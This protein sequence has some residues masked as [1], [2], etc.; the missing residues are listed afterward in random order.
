MNLIKNRTELGVINLFN[1]MFS[2]KAL[3][4]EP[5]LSLCKITAIYDYDSHSFGDIKPNSAIFVT[6]DKR[7]LGNSQMTVELAI[8]ERAFCR[9]YINEEER[10][11]AISDWIGYIAYHL[12]TSDI[13]RSGEAKQY[14]GDTF[15]CE[16]GLAKELLRLIYRRTKTDP[17]NAEFLNVMRN[18]IFIIRSLY[19]EQL[20]FD[21]EKSNHTLTHIDDSEDNEYKELVEGENPLL[22][23]D[24]FGVIYSLSKNELVDITKSLPSKYYVDNDTHVILENA[25]QPRINHIE[26]RT[27]LR[28]LYLPDELTDIRDG[29]FNYNEALTYINIPLYV[30]YIGAN[31]F[32]G[33]KRLH[34][35]NIQSP[36][37]IKVGTL[38]FNKERTR[39]IAC[40]PSQCINNTGKFWPLLEFARAHGK[41]QVGTFTNKDTEEHFHSCI[42]TNVEGVRIFCA[43][44]S[45]L[46]ELSP[47]EIANRKNELYVLQLPSG[48]YSLC[49]EKQ[50]FIA[51][52]EHVVLEEGL[53]YIDSNAFFGDKNLQEI[54][55]PSSLI[56]IG[57]NA[58][59]GCTSLKRINIPFGEREK[60]E[61][62]I[63]EAKEKLFEMQDELRLLQNYKLPDGSIYN[64]EAITH[65]GFI[66]LNGQGTIKYVNGDSYKGSFRNGIPNGWG[67]YTFRNGDTH[68]GYFDNLPNGIGYLNEVYS[69]SVGNFKDGRMNGWGI[70]YHNHIFKFGLWK[71]GRLI[72][73]ETNK[74]L[75]IRYEISSL[76]LEGYHASLIQ[77]DKDGSYIRF[78]IPERLM[79]KELGELP[80]APKWPALGFEFYNDGSVK[81]GIIKGHSE[82][83]YIL[84]KTDGSMVFGKWSKNK[85]LKIK[86]LSD[87]QGNTDNYTI[88]GFDVF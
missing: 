64:G 19:G 52:Q 65:W 83:N 32:A 18:R 61:E 11:V 29:A 12:K 70:R 20:N 56:E 63:P 16:L 46:G 54:T 74:T 36:N 81:V 6:I 9:T 77:I 4:L 33:C 71:E 15:V 14:V 35:V 88:D 25:L 84:C 82:G 13:E 5:I 38:L 86:T 72:Q 55:L 73:D 44:S 58:F 10:L 87:F 57:P 80:K 78:G 85:I 28:Q 31:P 69:M 47:V 1:S 37:F 76:R 75:W 34:Q 7:Q 50:I 3:A 43:F 26:D 79:N 42:F 24:S 22:L 68:K 27:T 41:M 21:G 2:T 59:Y 53:L 67:N 49:S 30:E 51:P 8:N 17:L 66:E 45:K 39:L 62:M 48:H 40:L 23:K 60:F